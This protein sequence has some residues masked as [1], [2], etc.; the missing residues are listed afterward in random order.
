MNNPSMRRVLTRSQKGEMT[1][2]TSAA[3]FGGIAWKSIYFAAVT[4]VAAVVAVLLI[5]YAI[6]IESGEMLVALLIT[7]GVAFVAMLILSLVIMLAPSTVMVAGTLY[8]LCQGAL[9]GM[10]VLLIDSVLPGV[11]L[12]SV[13]GTAIVFL[14]SVLANRFLGQ[15]IK[16]ALAKVMMISL[17]SLLLVELGV[18]IFSVASGSESWIAADFWIQV[19]IT[20]FCIFYASLLVMWDLQ[21]ANDI[22]AAGADK[23]YEWSVA[24]SLVVT[25]VYMYIQILELIIRLAL[26]F[27]KNK[28]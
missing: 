26:I 21:T 24:F 3:T 7:A 9:L 16:N 11:A 14:L 17:V 15:R 2:Q 27:G 1:V 25:L 19:A 10:V 8:S 13:L 5:L 28:N 18:A 23:K 20:A 12:T 4:V 22:V 6:S